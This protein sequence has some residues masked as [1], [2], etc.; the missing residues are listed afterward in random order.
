M[1]GH[2]TDKKITVKAAAKILDVSTKSIHRY[3]AK[4]RLTR[5]KEGT[6]TFILLHEVKALQ[7]HTILGQGRP[8]LS[9]KKT[10]GTGQVRDI[11]TLSRERYEQILI[12]LGELRKQSQ[13]FMEYKEVQLAKEEVFRR[14]R[15]DVEKLSE[16]ISTLE[17]SKF[18]E[19]SGGPEGTQEA[20]SERD[21]SSA[22]RKKPWWQV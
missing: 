7:G 11:V 20:P 12:E 19:F 5:I 1:E 16:R 17:M 22:K 2:V 10:C 4:G 3:L 21:Q 9:A 14:L 18:K 6:R 8:V 13:M 15:L